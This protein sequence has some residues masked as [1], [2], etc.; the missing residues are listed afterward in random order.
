M[1][2]FMIMALFGGP[3]FLCKILP[4]RELYSK[5]T[6]EQ[7]NLLFNVIKNAG[8]NNVAIICVGNRVNQGFCKMFN[9]RTLTYH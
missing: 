4:V 2:S 5:F 3:K 1:L 8:G 7:I 9:T 6:F